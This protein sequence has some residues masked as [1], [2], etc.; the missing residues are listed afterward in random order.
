MVTKHLLYYTTVAKHR[1]ER[2]HGGLSLY[3]TVASVNQHYI[4]EWLIRS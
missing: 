3:G 1:E 2:V 4:P